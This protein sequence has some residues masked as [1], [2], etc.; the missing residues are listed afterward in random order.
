MR[1]VSRSDRQ[2]WKD[3]GIDPG[4]PSDNSLTTEQLG[5]AMLRTVQQMSPEEKANLRKLMDQQLKDEIAALTP[6][7]NATFRKLRDQR[8]KKKPW[9]N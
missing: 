3:Y 2:F 5:E 4:V 9:I 7:E 6:A 8:L 1:K